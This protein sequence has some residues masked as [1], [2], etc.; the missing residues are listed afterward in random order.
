MQRSPS[1]ISLERGMAGTQQ[2]GLLS[3]PFEIRE[4]IYELLLIS[5]QWII[6]ETK[7]GYSI[8]RDE[9]SCYKLSKHWVGDPETGWSAQFLRV[10]KLFHAEASHFLYGRNKFELSL[11]TLERTFLPT[12]GKCNASCIRYVEL[13]QTDLPRFTATYTV[14]TVLSSLPSLRCLYLTP[15]VQGPCRH[16]CQYFCKHTPSHLKI[17]VLRLAHLVTT[18]HPHLKWFLEFKGEAHR[19]RAK[20]WYK[21]SDD[22]SSKHP[23][24]PHEHPDYRRQ[25]SNPRPKPGLEV[26]GEVVDI[27]QQL[28]RVKVVKV[29]TGRIVHR[30]PPSVADRP[31][32]RL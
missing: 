22:E 8:R 9:L 2:L 21:F 6:V 28:T 16:E 3:L 23:P 11:K 15:I 17:L 14:P 5:E 20:M 13:A 30:T 18:T 25:I 10:C 31:A 19:S 29:R 32:W 1:L 24:R 7:Y 26:M 4:M 27:E 12:I